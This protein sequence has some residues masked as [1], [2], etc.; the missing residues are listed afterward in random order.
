MPSFNIRYDIV[1]NGEIY[2]FLELNENLISEEYQFN[3]DTEVI[4]ALYVKY[5]TGCLSHLNGM[6]AFALWDKQDKTLLL[7][8]TA[9]VKKTTVLSF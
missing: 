3:T 2:N 9:W 5:V 7:H 6:F 4:L 8:V 1:F